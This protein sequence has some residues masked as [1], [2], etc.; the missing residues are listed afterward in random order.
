MEGGRRSRFGAWTRMIDICRRPRARAF[1]IG[2]GRWELPIH[3]DSKQRSDEIREASRRD[4]SDQNRKNG[5]S[6]SDHFF[7]FSPASRAN[8][9]ALR[10][11][12]FSWNS[13]S[14]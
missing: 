13:G 11:L 4:S 8:R 7:A 6:Q 14:A 10:R 9:S 12:W 3:F 1:Q 2:C 5:K